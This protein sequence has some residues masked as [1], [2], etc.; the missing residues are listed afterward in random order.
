VLLRVDY[1]HDIKDIKRCSAT[2]RLLSAI[3]I[4]VIGSVTMVLKCTAYC[5]PRAHCTGLESQK[6]SRKRN[7][8]LS[9]TTVRNELNRLLSSYRNLTKGIIFAGGRSEGVLLILSQGMGGI[10]D[11][12]GLLTTRNQGGNSMY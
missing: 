6:Q 1:C 5:Q 7:V 11:D 12:D 2:L 10:W 8:S 4:P 9:K 3:R